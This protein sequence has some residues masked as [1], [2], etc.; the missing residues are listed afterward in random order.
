M[1]KPSFTTLLAQK[2]GLLLSVYAILATQLLV[3]Y[4]IMHIVRTHRETPAAAA[5]VR[6]WW[7]WLIVAVACFL[8]MAFIRNTVVRT[9]LFCVATVAVGLILAGG[10]AKAKSE[11]A[12]RNGVIGAI[13]VFIVMSAAAFALTAA[14]VDLSFMGF[15]LIGG[16]VGLI[17]AALIILVA[18]GAS[19]LV[20]K[21]WTGVAIVLFSMFVTYDTNI[22]LLYRTEVLDAAMNFYLD[23]INL[24]Q[25]MM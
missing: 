2:R 22:L 4:G 8:G 9:S 18:G 25:L 15:F 16:L 20:H 13:G 21:I 23:V 19:P 10:A 24:T 11:E 3:A 5:V 7:V 6:F 1:A 14:G 12:V 17:I